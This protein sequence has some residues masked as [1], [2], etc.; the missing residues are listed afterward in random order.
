MT[1]PQEYFDAA[2]ALKEVTDIARHVL[3]TDE[4]AEYWLTQS[5]L[6]L[7]GPRPLDLLATAPG[8]RTSKRRR[9]YPSAWY[10]RGANNRYIDFKI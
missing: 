2:T 7:D 6:A 5:A 3:G 8:T 10:Q 4:L 1:M 9:C